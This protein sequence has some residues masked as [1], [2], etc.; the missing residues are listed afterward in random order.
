MQSID[1]ER[2]QFKKVIML[3]NSQGE[4]ANINEAVLWIQEASQEKI[5][6]MVSP[7]IFKTHDR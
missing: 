3:S 4:Q 2:F 5:D 6:S 7:R 1:Y